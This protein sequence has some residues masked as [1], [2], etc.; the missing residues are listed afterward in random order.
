[1]DQKDLDHHLVVGKCPPVAEVLPRDLSQDAPFDKVVPQGKVFHRVQEVDVLVRPRHPKP[2][3][4]FGPAAEHPCPY[5]E[6]G[7]RVDHTTEERVIVL[8]R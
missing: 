4:F 2:T 3:E 5:P 6:L 1:L 7:Q 8:A